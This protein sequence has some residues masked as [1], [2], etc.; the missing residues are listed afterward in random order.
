M[1]FTK[2]SYRAGVY[3]ATNRLAHARNVNLSRRNDMRNSAVKVVLAAAV[4]IPL[5]VYAQPRPGPDHGYS[6]AAD[7][8]AEEVRS[9]DG[10]IAFLVTDVAALASASIRI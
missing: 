5:V 8:L 3:F 4:L 6:Y 7:S 2:Q 9:L 10:T 1:R